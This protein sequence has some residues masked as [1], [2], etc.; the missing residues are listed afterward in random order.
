[1][2]IESHKEDDTLE[3]ST[4]DNPSSRSANP[5]GFNFLGLRNAKHVIP[6]GP[7]SFL[8]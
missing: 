3:I 8:L 5:L 7:N 1:M 4:V 6:I 2:I